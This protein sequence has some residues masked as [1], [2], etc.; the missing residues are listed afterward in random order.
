MQRARKINFAFFYS[1]LNIK[2]RNI[3]KDV[4]QDIIDYEINKRIIKKD[5]RIIVKTYI[6]TKK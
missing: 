5:Y 6:I 3:I 4:Y 2:M 1:K